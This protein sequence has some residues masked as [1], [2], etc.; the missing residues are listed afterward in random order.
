MAFVSNSPNKV[1]AL[2]LFAAYHEFSAEERRTLQQDEASV[3]SAVSEGLRLLASEY[4]PSEVLKRTP[5]LAKQPRE[6]F[7]DY[8]GFHANLTRGL[9]LIRKELQR[10][11]F[12][13]QRECE[14]KSGDSEAYAFVYPYRYPWVDPNIHI[15]PAYYKLG[16]AD[17]VGT[18]I[19]EMSH[20][21]VFTDHDTS[22]ATPPFERLPRTSANFYDQMSDPEFTLRN[23][24]LRL[25]VFGFRDPAE[26]IRERRKGRGP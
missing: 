15:C 5:D 17:R 16:D 10:N 11:E 23:T 6:V 2:G 18:L 25:S 14:C 3:R 20:L 26:V 22:I 9:L 4:R 8:V 13:A 7:L 12:E 24:V 21:W 19:H 1:D